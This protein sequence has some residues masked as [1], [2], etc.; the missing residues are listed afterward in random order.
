MSDLQLARPTNGAQLSEMAERLGAEAP[1]IVNYNAVNAAQSID[2]LLGNTDAVAILVYNSVQNNMPFGHWQCVTR[3][4]G[5]GS[6]VDYFDPYGREPDAGQTQG[7]IDA[8]VRRRYGIIH[9]KLY[10]LLANYP[11]ESTYSEFPL[12]QLDPGVQTCGRWVAAR[13]AMKQLSPEEFAFTFTQAAR[14]T[15][16]T[17]DQVVAGITPFNN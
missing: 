6:P 8:R 12:Q 4:N 7:L 14:A 5:P 3:R 15:N 10:E 11:G 9:P 1:R 16:Q 17:P 13:I 2:D